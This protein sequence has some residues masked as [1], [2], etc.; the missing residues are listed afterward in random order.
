MSH[1]ANQKRQR[2]S[3]QRARIKK[4]AKSGGEGASEGGG[5]VAGEVPPSPVEQTPPG[6][7]FTECKIKL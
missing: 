7:D 2:N 4:G 6:K 1:A 5:G 3:R